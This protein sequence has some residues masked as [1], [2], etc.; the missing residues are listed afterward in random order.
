MNLG[1]PRRSQTALAASQSLLHIR[2]RLTFWYAGTFFLILALLGIGM[3]ATITNRFDRDLDTSLLDAASRLASIARTGGS[4]AMLYIPDRRLYVTDATGRALDRQVVDDWIRALA[5][6]A[7]EFGH[8]D[9]TH[10]GPHDVQLRGYAT[11]FV[12]ATGE[13]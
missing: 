8:A 4:T 7:A 13:R 6:R 2:R 1:T 9:A 10:L 12:D 3:F 5:S 11:R